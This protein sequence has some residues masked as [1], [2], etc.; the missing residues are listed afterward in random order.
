MID[1]QFLKQNFCDPCEDYPLHAPF[2][3]DGFTF[4]GNRFLLVRVPGLPGLA[5]KPSVFEPAYL[6]GLLLS[7]YDG[8]WAP[9]KSVSAAVP[10]TCDECNGLGVIWL[11]PECYGEGTVEYV[12]Q[13]MCMKITCPN[14][15]GEKT[16]A[17]SDLE[18][19]CE[20]CE[21]VGSVEDQSAATMIG[22][23]KVADWLLRKIA[24]LPEVELFAPLYS[25]CP[26]R[27]VFRF[28]GGI[29]VVMG[30][31]VQ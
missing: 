1:S 16:V 17:G 31:E 10:R 26:Q 28:N 27:V 5:S 8:I 23:V 20:A 29:G 2:T 12:G 15:E 14:C 9:L 30:I 19:R 13:T 18:R 7:D 24:L 21:G 11:C 3:H 4:A 22:A 6:D 25:K